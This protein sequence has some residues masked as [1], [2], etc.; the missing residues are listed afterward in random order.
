MHEI[1]AFYDQQ[2]FTL[3]FLRVS[4]HQFF[5]ICIVETRLPILL[6]RVYSLHSVNSLVISVIKMIHNLV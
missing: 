3:L 2:I 5:Y 4:T 6:K 1:D